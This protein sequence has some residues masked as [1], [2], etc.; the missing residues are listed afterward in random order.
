MKAK[1]LT[2]IGLIAAALL[3]GGCNAKEEKK[4]TQEIKSGDF[5]NFA[6]KRKD[7]SGNDRSPIRYR[8]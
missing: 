8:K 5:D 1:V 4:S 6:P 7:T 3:M 2:L